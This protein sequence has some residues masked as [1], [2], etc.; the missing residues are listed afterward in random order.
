MNSNT[1]R[2]KL[3][4]GFDLNCCQDANGHTSGHKY[5]SFHRSRG[6]HIHNRSQ[7]AFVRKDS[8]FLITVHTCSHIRSNT[9]SKYKDPASIKLTRRVKR[10]PRSQ[11]HRHGPETPTNPRERIRVWNRATYVHPPRQ[12]G[13]WKRVRCAAPLFVACP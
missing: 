13:V 5:H 3:G 10:A 1:P 4:R 11:R 8:N 6:I 7:L 9:K 2:R 12:A